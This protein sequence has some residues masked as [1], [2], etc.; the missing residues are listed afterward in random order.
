MS[1]KGEE[2][3]VANIQE[4]S[5]MVSRF[6]FH[7]L[8]STCILQFEILRSEG[9]CIGWQGK[10]MKERIRR[11]ESVLALGLCLQGISKCFPDQFKCFLLV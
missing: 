5:R 3:S 9:A 6:V 10:E 4:K 11:G 8:C 1:E 2:C 7:Q